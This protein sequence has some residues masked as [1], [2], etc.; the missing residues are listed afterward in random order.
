MKSKSTLLFVL[1]LFS[2]MLS[3][4]QNKK[5]PKEGQMTIKIQK[6]INGKITLL[7]QQ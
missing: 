7:I 1:A 3:I 5:E 4:A 6:N 2:A